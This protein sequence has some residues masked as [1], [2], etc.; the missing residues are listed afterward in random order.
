V[1]YRAARKRSREDATT[2][3]C[4]TDEPL[5]ESLPTA[6][7]GS[8]FDGDGDGDDG[9]DDSGG[10]DEPSEFIYV[11]DDDDDDEPAMTIGKTGVH[12]EAKGVLVFIRS[13]FIT[14]S[15]SSS[16]SKLTLAF[17]LCTIT[18]RCTSRSCGAS[19]PS[20]RQ[21]PKSICSGEACSRRR[22]PLSPSPAACS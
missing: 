14:H 9:D 5:P 21:R 6:S 22:A 20:T 11:E 13:L 15:R 10:G 1:R 8:N 17:H 19:T 3:G 7:S 16:H 2:V 12:L 18:V 4:T